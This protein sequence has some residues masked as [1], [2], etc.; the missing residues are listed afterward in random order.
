MRAAEGGRRVKKA[1][2]PFDTGNPAAFELERGNSADGT[3]GLQPDFLNQ[4][5]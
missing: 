4:K 5:I 1:G 2:P 3:R